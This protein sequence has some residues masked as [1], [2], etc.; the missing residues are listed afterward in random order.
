MEA[1]RDTTVRSTRLRGVRVP[2]SAR[3]ARG[4]VRTAVTIAT[5]TKLRAARILRRKRRR[6]D[7][8][9]RRGAA[10]MSAAGAQRR[11][12]ARAEMARA[13]VA[14]RMAAANAVSTDV[15]A[16]ESMKGSTE[17]GRTLQAGRS[18]RNREATVSMATVASAASGEKVTAHSTMGRQ[19][20]IALLTA[21]RALL[22]PPE[23]GSVLA[24][25]K[26]RDSNLDE[27]IGGTSGA[28]TEHQRTSEKNGMGWSFPVRNGVE[29]SGPLGG[30]D[31]T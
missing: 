21:D 13:A 25:T 23:I 18:R 4:L 28:Q 7:G 24:L 20:R 29:F 30:S 26:K 3:E 14:R 19:E 8:I 31:W 11:G 5:V 10:V 1:R 12:E 9:V 17:E 6:S 27:L 16:H 22:R 2:A 15:H